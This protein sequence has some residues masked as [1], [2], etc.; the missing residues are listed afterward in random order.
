MADRVR[1]L[2]WN[3]TVTP[4]KSSGGNGFPAPFNATAAVD[5]YN[6]Q[7]TL[8]DCLKWYWRVKEW[9]VTADLLVT[10]PGG[11]AFIV[12]G[13]TATV[14]LG[15]ATEL[16]M[17]Q[18]GNHWLHNAMASG[19]TNPAGATHAALL[20]FGNGAVSPEPAIKFDAPNH[21]PWLEVNAIVGTI[22]DGY[23]QFDSIQANVSPPDGSITA[24]VDGYAVTLY[25]QSHLDP[26]TTLTGS[27]L[28]FTPVSY[29]PYAA[30]DGTP[31]Y[32]SATGAELQ[33]PRN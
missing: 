32:D 11:T 2:T 20:L 19:G 25:Y 22:I 18:Q 16:D 27:S 4:A 24:I 5:V 31:I 6:T 21:F 8:A 17:I 29:W 33:D 1:F 10:G 7:V 13:Q 3:D 15:P 26:G 9:K 28:V 12:S 14:V 30:A 23:V